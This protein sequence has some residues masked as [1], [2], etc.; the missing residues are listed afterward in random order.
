MASA[1][2]RAEMFLNTATVALS[3]HVAPPA[4]FTI[5]VRSEEAKSTGPHPAEVDDPHRSAGSKV[6]LHFLAQCSNARVGGIVHHLLI[7]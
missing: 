3:D 7:V 6:P 4:I 2:G 5:P 1:S